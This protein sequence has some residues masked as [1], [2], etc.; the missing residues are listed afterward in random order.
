MQYA[1]NG[2][3]IVGIALDDVVKVREYAAEFRVDYPLLMGGME[4]LS[5]TNDIGNRAGVLPFTIV[6]DRRGKVVQANTGALTEA[7]L[8]AILAPLL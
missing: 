4:T 2:V 5:I 1:P 6:L 7:S 3:I 8:G